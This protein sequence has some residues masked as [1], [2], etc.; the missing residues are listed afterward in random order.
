VLLP[1]VENCFKHGASEEL[2]QSWVKVSVDVQPHVTLM[3][4]E[5]NKASENGIHKPA[6]IGI[7]NVKRRLDLIYPA[8]H[9]LKII[10]G[11]ETFLVILT[12]Q[13]NN[14]I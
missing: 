4:V 13:N 9:E 10:N 11:E 6:G 5:N 1:F 12:I 14:H 7:Q 3:K 2:Q 8:Q